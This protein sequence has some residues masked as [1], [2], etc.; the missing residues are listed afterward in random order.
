MND[1]DIDSPLDSTSIE[2]INPP[3]WGDYD[4]Q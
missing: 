2:I 1:Y 3:L 4:Q